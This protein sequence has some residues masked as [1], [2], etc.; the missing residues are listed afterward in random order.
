MRLN[1]VPVTD[2]KAMAKLSDLAA[3]G[4]IKLSVGKKQHVLIRPV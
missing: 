2:V 1:D 4:A 3:E